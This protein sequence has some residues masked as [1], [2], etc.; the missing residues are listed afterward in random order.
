MEQLFISLTHAIESTPLIALGA[1]FV[2]GILSILLSP[3]HLASI[4]MIIGFI[5]N[6]GRTS[7][8]RA[9]VTSLMFSS[10]MLFTIVVIGV[11]T[12]TMGRMMGDV[13]QYGNYF[14]ALIFFLV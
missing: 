3:C 10:G 4:P 5:D 1:A 9:F 7:A 6:Q 12:A 8:K 2:W 11:I 13:G 14:V